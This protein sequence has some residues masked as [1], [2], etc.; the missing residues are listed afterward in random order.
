MFALKHLN[1]P[2][3]IPD[4]F[5][6]C[7]KSSKG[8]YWKFQKSEILKNQFRLKILQWAKIKHKTASLRC[9]FAWSFPEDV[10][11]LRIMFNSN[12]IAGLFH[13]SVPLAAF[14]LLLL[15]LLLSTIFSPSPGRG[16]KLKKHLSVSWLFPLFIQKYHYTKSWLLTYTEEKAKKQTTWLVLSILI[17]LISWT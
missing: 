11:L 5:V 14:F 16:Y 6:R 10:P 17:D 13:R 15:L 4:K 7:W 2:D 3:N 12:L 8:A 9:Y 1:F